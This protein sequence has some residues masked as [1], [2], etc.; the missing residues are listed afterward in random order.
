MR[1][2]LQYKLDKLLP[3][4]ISATSMYPDY[5][6]KY[7]R[8]YEKILK[9]GSIELFKLIGAHYSIEVARLIN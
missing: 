1:I 6:P 5:T 9:G 4:K 7:D 3:D 2:D 8:K